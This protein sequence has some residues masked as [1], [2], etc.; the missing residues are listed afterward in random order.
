MADAFHEAAVTGDHIGIVIDK[1][2][3]KARAQHFFGH[4]KADRV[5]NPLTER[6]GGGLDALRVAI[7]RVT[8][9][10]RAPLA[11]I[12]HL[13]KRHVRVAGEMQQRIKQ[14]RAM[15]RRQDEAVAIGP[16]GVGGIKLEVVLKKHR[17]HIGHAHRHAGMAGIGGSHGIQ[18]QG[19]NGGGF[20]PVVGIGRAQGGDIHGMTSFEV[21]TDVGCITARPQRSSIAR[22]N[23]RCLPGDWR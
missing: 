1:L 23:A 8:C 5:G 6:A 11:E 9:G 3:P 10:N 2:A 20:F 12:F 4:G 16:V 21:A 13:L 15:P 7:F 22:H 18:R 14:H 17:R 19:A